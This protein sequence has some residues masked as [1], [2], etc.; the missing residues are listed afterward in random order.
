MLGLLLP[1]FGLTSCALQRGQVVIDP[2][3]KANIPP[4]GPHI[5]SSQQ[6]IAIQFSWEGN[7]TKDKNYLLA[8]PP[9]THL[10][11]RL[12]R[13]TLERT[14]NAG[15]TVVVTAK[16]FDRNPGRYL[17]DYA[18]QV[19][20][21]EKGYQRYDRLVSVLLP[22]RLA[23]GSEGTPY[24]LREGR[25]VLEF[26]RPWVPKV[27]QDASL[28]AHPWGFGRIAPMMVGN[29]SAL[30][31][32]ANPNPPL[33]DVEAREVWPPTDPLYRGLHWGRIRIAEPGL[34]KITAEQIKALG[35]ALDKVQ[36]RNFR[37]FESGRSVPIHVVG[38]ASPSFSPMDAL[39]FSA[40]E[41][42]TA[43][44]NKNV[45]WLT[46]SERLPA[47]M[48][49]LAPLPDV[50]LSSV[51]PMGLFNATV[52]IEED[53]DH[54]VSHGSFLAIKSMRWVWRALEADNT[55]A[56]S[57]D[58]PGLVNAPGNAKVGLIFY[59]LPENYASGSSVEVSINGGAKE[60][61]KFQNANDDL[62]T[63]S[64]LLSQLRRE[65]NELTV[66]F[67]EPA[68]KAANKGVSTY[69]DA[70]EVT[71][72]RDF[73]AESLPFDIT[74]DEVTS[75]L[76]RRLRVTG[77]RGDTLK[78]FDLSDPISP[79]VFS[80]IPEGVGGASLLLPSG[81]PALHLRVVSMTMLPAAEDVASVG[82]FALPDTT[83]G[84][85]YLVVYHP[86]FADQ[87]KQLVALAQS[88]GLRAASVTI[89]RL[90][91]VFNF[92]LSSPEA[93]KRYLATLLAGGR[94]SAPTYVCLLGDA[95][96][97]Y[98][99]EARKGVENLVPTY[100][101]RPSSAADEKWASDHWFTTVAG[102]DELSDFMIG[103]VSVNN[104]DDAQA[105][106]DKI[107]NYATKNSYGPWRSHVGY[108]A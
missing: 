58:L 55:E 108:V 31:L 8:V 76:L 106:I 46:C 15:A 25:L 63:Y 95:S 10:S 70:L 101:R 47:A 102:E 30:S 12:E 89:E 20:I 7:D 33:R 49:P 27:V 23:A 73:R 72:A 42:D 9:D 54:I 90:F 17:G 75:P 105:I 78:A 65:K 21:S 35:F 32:Y 37:L 68:S 48:I 91:D 74:L 67:K 4:A 94:G 39:V 64:V 16:E 1:I 92:G 57:F 45:Y 88:R 66:V 14:D 103:R 50:D 100:T 43:Y 36:P 86:R 18:K 71:Y 99:D 82:D 26:D 59:H 22:A 6:S 97:D 24:R 107:R 96:S 52:R 44:T 56:F 61:F 104:V 13:V 51:H 41:P 93:L 11:P 5:E 28:E 60:I 34:Y 38:G 98:R 3:P 62:K 77:L 29:P 80:M 84:L 69:F 53:N 85:D 19:R 87:A 81:D 83:K 40:I 2:P 79:R